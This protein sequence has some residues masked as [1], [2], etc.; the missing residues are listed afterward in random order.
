MSIGGLDFSMIFDTG[1][2]LVFVNSDYC[3][4]CIKNKTV[5][6]TETETLEESKFE[7]NVQFGNGE[8][9]GIVSR[10]NIK[11]GD[12]SIEKGVFV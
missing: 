10:D 5:Y 12:I 2:S 4:E 7:V 8:M 1:S 3:E 9:H 11:L 6:Y